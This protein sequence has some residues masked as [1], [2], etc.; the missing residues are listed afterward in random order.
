MDRNPRMPFFSLTAAYRRRFRQIALQ[1]M[2]TGSALVATFA[3]LLFG[4]GIANG[5]DLGDLQQQCLPLGANSEKVGAAVEFLRTA[6]QSV[7][8]QKKQA[9]TV[10]A[11]GSDSY[12]LYGDL[13]HTG[14]N[15]ALLTMDVTIDLDSTIGSRRTIG[16]GFAQ[17]TG[18]DWTARGFW[19]IDPA[20]LPRGAQ[21]PADVHYPITP[22]DKPFWVMDF[23]GNGYWGVVMV[24]YVYRYWQEHYLFGFDPKQNLLV[25]IEE[26]MGAPRLIHGRMRLYSNSGH[27]SIFQEWCF[28]LWRRDRFVDRVSWHEETPYNNVDPY[29]FRVVHTDSRGRETSYKA[30]NEPAGSSTQMVYEITKNEKPFAH[31]AFKWAEPIGESDGTDEKYLFEKLTGLPRSMFPDSAEWQKVKITTCFQSVR[32]KGEREAVKMLSP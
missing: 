14:R 28:A 8:P 17:W 7:R 31:I 4:S 6:L 24:G 22:S 20:W 9:A 10:I 3:L 11:H 12:I 26:T 13:F 32:V 15:Y 21:P 16:V 27:R 5:A 23:N 19:C 18:T 29:F 30:V 2:M 1:P 25:P